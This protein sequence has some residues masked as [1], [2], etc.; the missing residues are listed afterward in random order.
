MKQISL[1][2][3]FCW[4]FQSISAQSIELARQYYEDAEYEKAASIY[5]SLWNKNK[6]NTTYL[7]AL[8]DCYVALKDYDAAAKVVSGAVEQFPGQLHLRVSYASL[9]SKMDK[10][11]EAEK[12]YKIILKD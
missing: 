2:F 6:A 7:D 11:A 10:T 12:Q 5:Q 3:F 9:L 8:T 4:F 1:I